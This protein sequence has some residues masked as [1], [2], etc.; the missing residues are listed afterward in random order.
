MIGTEDSHAREAILGLLSARAN[1]A[2]ICPSEAARAL[3]KAQVGASDEWRGFMPEVHAA[4]DA[5]LAE[6]HVQ[7]SWK[8]QPLAIRTGPY[9]IRSR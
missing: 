9:R 7:L 8:G 2:T 6:G 4:V 5:L 1:E 3:A